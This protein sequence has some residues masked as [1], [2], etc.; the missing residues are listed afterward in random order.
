VESGT[1]SAR[2]GKQDVRPPFNGEAVL[3]LKTRALE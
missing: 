3:Y 2:D 1:L